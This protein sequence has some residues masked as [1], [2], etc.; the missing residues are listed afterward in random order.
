MRF[1]D[2]G[3]SIGRWPTG[4]L[5][6]ITDVAGLRVGQVSCVRDGETVLRTGAT[7]IWPHPGNPYLERVYAATD[8]LNGYGIMTGR[9]VIAEWG[10]LGSPV[11]LTNTRSIGHAYEAVVQELTA[12]DPGTGHFD[13]VMP[14]VAECDDGYLNDNRGPAIPVS[15]IRQALQGARPGETV[16]EGAVGAGCGTQ[17]FGFKGGI[18]TSSRRVEI[19]GV[20]YTLGVL[21]NTNF[22][23]RHQMIVN[24]YPVGRELQHELLPDYDHEGSCIGVLATDAPLWPN[25]LRRLAKRIGLGLVR[26][27][28][29]GNDGSGEIFLAFSTARRVPREHAGPLPSSHLVDGQFW[30]Q[31]SPIDA[32]FEAT[33]EASE[34]AVMN[35][36]VAAKTVTGRDGHRLYAFPVERYTSLLGASHGRVGH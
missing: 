35:A 10:L 9:A 27:G 24:G 8:I 26:T 7:V 1:R 14:V 34:E 4:P 31:G 12:L 5:N 13:V 28:S 32:L 18:G 2:F 15:I 30:T 17:L 33:V 6:A 22:G 36:L 19:D 29:V 3:G 23:T 16:E 21:V 25:Q 20:T 11:V